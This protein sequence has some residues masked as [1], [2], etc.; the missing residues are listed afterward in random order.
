MPQDRTAPGNAAVTVTVAEL[1]SGSSRYAHGP[2]ITVADTAGNI[3]SL[4]AEQI[5][6]F[7]KIDLFRATDGTL[8]LRVDQ[9]LA[10][11]SARMAAGNEV[12]VLDTAAHIAALTD[13]QL[14]TLANVDQFQTTDPLNTPMLISLAQLDAFG[15]ERVTGVAITLLDTQEK[16]AGLTAGQISV[17]LHGPA[18]AFASS[19]GELKFNADQALAM[20]GAAIADGNVVTIADTGARLQALTME[21][22]YYGRLGQSDR[23][24]FDATD[25]LLTISSI[26]AAYL[27]PANLSADDTVTISDSGMWIGLLDLD[28]LGNPNVD[29]IHV[30]DGVPIQF[31]VAQATVALGKLDSGAT[32]SL[33]D[34]GSALDSDLVYDSH[35]Q[36]I[37]ATD[38]QVV[39][40]PTRAPTLDAEVAALSKLSYY[41]WASLSQAGA[42]VEG[43]TIATAALLDP[44]VCE[45]RQV[46]SGP[47]AQLRLSVST[48]A[49]I[50]Q[51][52]TAVVLSDA[53]VRVAATSGEDVLSD[54][55]LRGGTLTL[56]Y[57]TAEQAGTAAA[58]MMGPGGLSNG[59]SFFLQNVDVIQHW[60]HFG[61]PINNSEAR[62]I[63]KLSNFNLTGGTA[64]DFTGDGTIDNGHFL[65]IRGSFYG[66]SFSVDENGRDTL[67]V[68]DAD[69]G[70]GVRQA[71]AVVTWAPPMMEI[72]VPAQSGNVQIGTQP[73]VILTVADALAGNDFFRLVDTVIV[74]DS[75]AN[76][77]ALSADQIAGLTK[78]DRFFA[79]DNIVHLHL[80]VAQAVAMGSP[81]MTPFQVTVSDTA[82]AIEALSVEQ[83]HSLPVLKYRPTDGALTF[84]A[85]QIGAVFSGQLSVDDQ[86]IVSDT[87]ANLSAMFSGYHWGPTLRADI[88]HVSDGGSVTMDAQQLQLLHGI[89]DDSVHIALNDTGWNLSYSQ[90]LDDPHVQSIHAIDGSPIQ[91]RNPDLLAK[92]GDG[93]VVQLLLPSLVEGVNITTGQLLDPHIR[94]IAPDTGDI[95]LS[96]ATLNALTGGGVVLQAPVHVEATA[97]KDVVSDDAI[98]TASLWLSYNSNGLAATVTAHPAGSVLANGDTFALAGVDRIEHDPT[99]TWV[100]DLVS[101]GPG[102]GLAA[103]E[104]PSLH[105]AMVGDAGYALV[106]GKLDGDVFTADASGSDTLVLWDDDAASGR[107]KQC[108]VV[109][110]G[111]GPLQHWYDEA[112]HAL[113]IGKPE[114]VWT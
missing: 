34:S 8:Q 53:G 43:A 21:K 88:L 76:I 70:S 93:D 94:E 12:V 44:H 110:V 46:G 112:G 73:P 86:L 24:H 107:V 17:F 104:S 1:L 81:R 92:L 100:R 7:D 15:L 50:N 48:L 38:G 68:W 83:L 108:G 31:N 36:E 10:M 96:I 27:L 78:V 33:R 65:A 56:E 25:N 97:G 22:W 30:T 47:D 45:I 39:S 13:K 109:V 79:T 55:Q 3:A 58:T 35:V 87:A 67:I 54:M 89:L 14:A 26:D 103:T 41:T 69:S 37:S 52:A 28:H 32:I 5:A 106:L 23:F 60:E 85:A 62:D 40:W 72:G 64:A 71:A 6:G 29:R 11:G 16:I 66:G 18:R 105:G 98:T 9:A 51:A 90:Y 42:M 2:N 61:D 101:L 82:A 63:I 84:T 102:L 114:P 20:T 80:S 77:A 113:V 49:A 95:K 111:A 99:G 75:G 19:S 57:S 74:A 91:L 4:T 59:D